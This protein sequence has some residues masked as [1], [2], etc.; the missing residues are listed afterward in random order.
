[1]VFRKESRHDSFQ[2]QISALRQQLSADQDAGEETEGDANPPLRFTPTPEAPFRHDTPAPLPSEIHAAS[3][4]TGVIA[5]GSSWTGS[6][7]SE[8][9]VH[10]YGVVE[11]EITAEQDVFVAEGATVDARVSATNVIVAG[12]LGGTIACRNRLEVWPTGH[13]SGDVNSPSLVIHEGATVDG[14][15]T[16]RPSESSG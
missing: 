14:K 9:S 4:D 6:M 3:A 7:I 11:G 16:M 12:R 8:G 1:M 2:R 15:V 5:A 10:I 13:I